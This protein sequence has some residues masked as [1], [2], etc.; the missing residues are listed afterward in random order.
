MRIKVHIFSKTCRQKQ[1]LLIQ[2]LYY[3]SYVLNENVVAVSSV[4][5]M[6]MQ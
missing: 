4:L 5:F 2:K 3:A 1:S 6:T